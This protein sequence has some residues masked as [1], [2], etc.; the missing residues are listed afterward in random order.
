M[1]GSAFFNLAS[2]CSRG[3]GC[4]SRGGGAGGDVTSSV[5]RAAPAEQPMER[6]ALPIDRAATA[7]QRRRLMCD[8]CLA[9]F[10]PATPLRFP[11]LCAGAHGEP[12]FSAAGNITPTLSLRALWKFQSLS[13]GWILQQQ[14]RRRGRS[15]RWGCLW[16]GSATPWVNWWNRCIPT[17]PQSAPAAFSFESMLNTWWWGSVGYFCASLAE[18]YKSQNS[19]NGSFRLFISNFKW[20]VAPKM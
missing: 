5:L 12:S 1:A 13:L 10:R 17:A 11:R 9:L 6:D 18:S 15:P 19:P 2:E 4:T 20:H 14:R 8:S 3:S 7:V 16:P